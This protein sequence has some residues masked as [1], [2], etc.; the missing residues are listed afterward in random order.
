[1]AGP[2]NSKTGLDCTHYI[3]LWCARNEREAERNLADGY[4]K[5]DREK[6]G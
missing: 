4:P 3:A 5:L 6:C 2:R 1:M